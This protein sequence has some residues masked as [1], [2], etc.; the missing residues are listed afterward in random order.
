[1]T[2]ARRQTPLFTSLTMKTGGTPG[3]IY[4]IRSS[5]DLM[6][7]NT[8]E[9]TDLMNSSGAMSWTAPAAP[10]GPKKFYRLQTP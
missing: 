8:V 4:D 9:R 7:W 10:T 1:M 6:N 2:K 3:E 5:I